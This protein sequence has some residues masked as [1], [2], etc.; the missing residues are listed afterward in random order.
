MTSLRFL[1]KKQQTR[2]ENR[3]NSGQEVPKKPLQTVRDL[4][5]LK[6]SRS[7]WLWRLDREHRLTCRN[8]AKTLTSNQHNVQRQVC[9]QVYANWVS[10]W[11]WGAGMMSAVGGGGKLND[12]RKW[13]WSECHNNRKWEF[14]LHGSSHWLWIEIHL[15][16]S[17][18]EDSKTCWIS[19]ED[20]VSLSCTSVIGYSK[21]IIKLSY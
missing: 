14:S 18:T 21:Y 15:L 2:S 6:S 7:T 8:E 5:R 1:G 9:E 3:I 20:P 19:Y 10:E 12:V 16:N 11:R 4:M 17:S 13:S